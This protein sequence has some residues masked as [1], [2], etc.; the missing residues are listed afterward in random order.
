[1]YKRQLLYWYF[2]STTGRSL[3]DMIGGTRLIDTQSKLSVEKQEENTRE[4][5]DAYFKEVSTENPES[6]TEEETEYK[7]I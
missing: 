5:V 3:A 4:Y 6:A 2:S 1:M 7:V